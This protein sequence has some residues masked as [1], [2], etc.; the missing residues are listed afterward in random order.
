MQ[1]YMYAQKKDPGINEEDIHQCSIKYEAH[2]KSRVDGGHP[3]P[4]GEGVLIWDETKVHR[5]LFV[6]VCTCTCMYRKK[7]INYIIII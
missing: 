1:S 6:H 5:C 4:L 2:K 3:V 7:G